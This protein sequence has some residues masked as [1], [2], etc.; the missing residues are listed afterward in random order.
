M[1]KICKN[2]G[3]RDKMKEYFDKH[4]IEYKELGC[5]GKCGVC[6]KK[7]FFTEEGKIH[8]F[9]SKEEFKEYFKK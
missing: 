9:E 1:I 7:Y 4:S 3:K 6:G 8:I 2:S 5:I